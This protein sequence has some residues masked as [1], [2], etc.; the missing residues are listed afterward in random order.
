VHRHH[1]P[2]LACRGCGGQLELSVERATGEYVEEGALRC[3]PCGIN[4]PV[5]GGVPRFSGESYVANFSKQWQKFADFEKYHPV[6]NDAYYTKGLGLRPADVAGKRVLEI[7]CGSGRAVGHFLEGKP[8]ILVA[9]DLSQAV[10][11]VAARFHEREE[12]LVLQCDMAALPLRKSTFDVVYSYGVLHHTPDPPRYFAAVAELVA[13]GGLLSIWVYPKGRNFGVISNWVQRRSHRLP[14]W[15]LTPFCWLMTCLTCA[16][17]WLSRIP[18]VKLVSPF[19]LHL[20]RYFFRIT[21]TPH[22]KLAYLW[23]HDFHTT[24][25]TTEHEP[26]EVYGWFASAGFRDMRPLRPCGMVAR[27]EEA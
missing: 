14:R 13:P 2:L 3:A 8:Q 24:R 26:A 7:G 20:T 18:V 5:R 23:A 25:Y 17:H 1:L 22:P 11:V 4:V 10:D 12:V 27:R 9:I 21:P 19:C 15:F 16:H 6:D